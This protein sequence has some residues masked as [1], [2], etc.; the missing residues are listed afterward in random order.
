[1]PYQSAGEFYFNR[2]VGVTLQKGVWETT[3]FASQRNIS[4][5]VV[6]D[7][8]NDYFTS[9]STSGLHRTPSELTDK[10]SV[11]QASFGG[12]VKLHLNNFN[13]GVNAVQYHFSK[14]LQKRNE[15]YNRYAIS[16]N[17]WNNISADYNFIYKNIYFFG[18]AARDRRGALAFVNGLIASVDPKIDL[19]L[20]QRRI[21][22]AYQALYGNAFTENIAPTNERGFYIGLTV[23]PTANWRINSYADF[24]NF[25]W[26]K[27]GVDAP[28]SGQ[29][30]LIQVT[31]QPNK[32]LE[33]Y[34]RFREEQKVLNELTED[35]VMHFAAPK[36]R[37]NFRLNFSY[38]VNPALTLKAR[39]EVVL[40]D[41]KNSDAEKGFLF[42]LETLYGGLKK[43][44][45]NVRLQYFNT[46]G[47][48]SRIYAY[49][50]DV[51]Y[52]YS[53]PAF[54]N[55]GFRYYFNLQYHVFKHL[56]LWLR[57]SQTIYPK[58]TAIGTGLTSIRGNTRS[59]VKCQASYR[60]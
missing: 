5:N 57:W 34:G 49:E 42:Y 40:Y 38:Q 59:E 20:V 16:G 31:Y 19:A 35:S 7:S 55:S 41:L 15:A 22:S 11:E 51:L 37:Q 33:V 27:Y 39:S 60:L 23:R 28:S 17:N 29:E 43:W 18:E 58:S 6:T 24:F 14:S 10:N 46:D 48:N 4:A 8:T 2:G 44:K 45:G 21:S 53:I 26:L 56:S 52:S 12:S 9:F 1:M 30:H 50:S 36:K 47:Y 25:P 3:V 13:V 54:F 32:K